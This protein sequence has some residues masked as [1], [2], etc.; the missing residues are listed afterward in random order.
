MS[1]MSDKANVSEQYKSDQNL[2]IRMQLHAKYS[3]NKYGLYNWMFDKYRFS[4]TSGQTPQSCRILE[5]GCGTA[6]FWDSRIDKLPA[7][8]LLVLTDMSEH[9]TELV[10]NKHSSHANLIVQRADIQSLPFPDSSFD[11]VIANHMLYH[12]PDLPKAVSEVRRVLNP[13]GEFYAATNGDEG[14]SKYLHHALKDF[15]SS[16]NAFGEEACSFTLQNGNAVLSKYFGNVEAQ[17]YEDSLMITDTQALVDWLL[18]T[19]SITG[20]PAEKLDGIYDYYESIRI[21]DGAISIPKQVGMF[22][23]SSPMPL[24]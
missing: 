9:M 18:S 21:R 6:S 22:V 2:S 7:G 13:H 14:M 15:N 24:S 17:E 16:I 12:V 1:S 10:W 4:S 5:L 19:I 3:T 11:Y 20:I 8:A 23:S